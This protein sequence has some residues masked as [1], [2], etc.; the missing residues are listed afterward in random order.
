MGSAGTRSWGATPC[1]DVLWEVPGRPAGYKAAR[2]RDPQLPIRP[3]PGIAC[4]RAGPGDTPSPLPP[5]P[6]LPLTLWRVNVL[7][8]NQSQRSPGCSQK[9]FSSNINN[10]SLWKFTSTVDAVASRRL[11]FCSCFG[12]LS[13][14]VQ[15]GLGLAAPGLG[16]GGGYSSCLWLLLLLLFARNSRNSCYF[17]SWRRRASSWARRACSSASSSSGSSCAPAAAAACPLRAQPAPS[18]PSRAPPSPRPPSGAPQSCHSRTCL[19]RTGWCDA[20]AAG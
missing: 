7:P 8:A 19:C 14:L 2:L 12:Q 20:S 10:R 13:L 4:R 18:R 3:A 9:R 16:G 1:A 5:P 17:S 11:C 6:L 15:H